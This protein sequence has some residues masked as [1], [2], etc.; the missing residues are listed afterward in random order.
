MALDTG[1]TH[2][3]I[4]IEVLE[5]IGYCPESSLDKVTV[6]TGGGEVYAPVL[7]IDSFEALGRK[8]RNFSVTVSL[9]R[10]ASIDGVVG[11]DFLRGHLLTLDFQE[12][13][14]HFE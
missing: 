12:G 14:I 4:R 6:A 5:E 9:P 2:T 1:A 7:K 10:S 11:L 3:F 13:L 8:H